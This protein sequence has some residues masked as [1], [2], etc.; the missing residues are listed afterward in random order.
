MSMQARL[1]DLE[2]VAIESDFTSVK[3]IS[4]YYSCAIDRVLLNPAIA[5]GPA[6]ALANLHCQRAKDTKRVGEMTNFGGVGEAMFIHELMFLHS[7]GA[8]DPQMKAVEDLGERLFKEERKRKIAALGTVPCFPGL[9][10]AAHRT[11]RMPTATATGAR[12]R[13]TCSRTAPEGSRR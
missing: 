2:R 6:R 5:D 10:A 9:A 11:C 1:L 12:R 8:K 13:A 4:E 3:T 7:L